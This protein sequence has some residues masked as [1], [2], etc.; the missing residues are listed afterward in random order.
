MGE[1]EDVVKFAQTRNDK[2][3]VRVVFNKVRKATVLGRLV[4]ESAKQVSVPALQVTLSYRECYI[5][6]IAQGW[7]AL[8]GAP[9]EEVLQLAVALLSLQD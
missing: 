2:A 1:A 5:H 8:D 3:A 9:R 7:K 4:D 6:A